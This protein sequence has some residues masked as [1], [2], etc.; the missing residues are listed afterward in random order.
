M[1]Q[2]LDG[3]RFEYWHVI[4]AV[5]PGQVAVAYRTVIGRIA[6]PWA[7]VH[8]SEVR[9]GRY[10]NPLRAHAMGPYADDTRPVVGELRP[11]RHG[12]PLEGAVGGVV[13]LVTGAADT[14][15]LPLPPAWSRA[16]LTPALVRWRIVGEDGGR[17]TPWR[18]A[19]DVR[20]QLPAAPF[21]SV[22]ATGT[23]QNRP[24]RPGWYRFYLAHAWDTRGLRNGD[25][26]VQVRTADVRGNA[27]VAERPITIRN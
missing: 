12:R 20:S 19:F 7:H 16:V 21:A 25:Y 13:E 14:P 2:R 10:V 1:V 6:A 22:F 27:R 11:E 9:G 4:P 18:T 24:N 15:V 17:A 23:R 3:V 26:T 8:F 5:R